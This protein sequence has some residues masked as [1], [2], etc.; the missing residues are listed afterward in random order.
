[1]RA[2]F[3][4]GWDKPNIVWILYRRVHDFMN[5]GILSPIHFTDMLLRKSK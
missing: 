1:M 2:T 4:S 5:V 3:W